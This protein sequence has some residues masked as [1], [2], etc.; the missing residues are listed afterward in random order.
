M[1]ADKFLAESARKVFTYRMLVAATD[2]IA[3]AN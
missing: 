3:I 2:L 1:N